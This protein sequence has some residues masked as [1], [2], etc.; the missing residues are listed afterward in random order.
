MYQFWLGIALT[1]VVLLSGLFQYY[2]DSKSY[3]IMKAFE[4]LIP[5]VSI[6]LLTSV[7]TQEL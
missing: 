3:K 1:A 6:R 7:V 2:Q 4:N 5:R